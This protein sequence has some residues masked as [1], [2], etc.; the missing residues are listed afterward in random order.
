MIKFFRYIKELV[1]TVLKNDPASISFLQVLL[2]SPGIKALSRHYIEHKLWNSG[3]KFLAVRM[4]YK[5]RKKTGIEIHPGAKFG[6]RTM[7][8]HGMGIVI[9]ETTIIGDDVSIFHGV[10][11]GGTTSARDR[12]RHPTIKN[13]VLIGASSIILGDI[14][15]GDHAKIGANSVVLED[16]PPYS[17]AVGS[18]A[19]VIYHKERKWASE[20]IED[21]KEENIIDRDI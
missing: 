9:G 10:T 16:I 18:P 15:I 6:R 2:Y 19:K 21:L 5:T 3:H 12:K 11:L 8:D 17:T 20:I 13:G 14:S 1:E 7:I 4:S